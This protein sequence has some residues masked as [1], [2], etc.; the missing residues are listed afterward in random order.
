MD[1]RTLFIFFLLVIAL[2]IPACT[3]ASQPTAVVDPVF[4]QPSG[5]LPESDAE[6]PRASL[7]EAKAAL[8]N[9]TAIFVDVRSADAY[10]AS[11]VA[12]ALSIPLA[13]VEA[14]PSGLALDQ[15]QWIITYCT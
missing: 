9:G 2:A 15:E 11:H 3:A 4:T 12:G 8:D 6:V 1:R 5:N 14:N 7:E 10:E 13:E